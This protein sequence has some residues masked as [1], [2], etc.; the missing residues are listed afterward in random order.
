[1]SGAEYSR[2]A[3]INRPKA[4]GVLLRQ[5]L[6]AKLDQ[7]RDKP[8]IWVSA[9]GGSGK[10]TLVSSYID[11]RKL[12]CL[13]HTVDARDADPATFFYYLGLALLGKVS[14]RRK[15]LPHLTPERLPG[16]KTFARRYFEQRRG[17][18]VF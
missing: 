3:K 9:P 7:I 1:M 16:I 14:G 4:P 2:I 18:P 5:R 6:F 11:S 10:T 12:R 17:W 15:T 13:W 8:V